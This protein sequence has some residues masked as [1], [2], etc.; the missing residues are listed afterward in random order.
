QVAFGIDLD[1]LYGK[2]FR[3]LCTS[4]MVWTFA[5]VFD[6]LFDFLLLLLYFYRCCLKGEFSLVGITLEALTLL[7]EL[8]PPVHGKLGFQIIYLFITFSQGLITA[9]NE[10]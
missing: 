1:L 3:Q 10:L 5:G 6:L 2:V 9:G 7:S 4:L 8:H